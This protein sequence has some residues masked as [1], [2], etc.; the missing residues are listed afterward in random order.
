MET[1]Y[2]KAF[3]IFSPPPSCLAMEKLQNFILFLGQNF[4]GK[5]KASWIYF[6]PYYH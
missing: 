5:E 1:K 4:G 6:V 3:T 2:K